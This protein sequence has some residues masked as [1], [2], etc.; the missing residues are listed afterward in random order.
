MLFRS[1][2]RAALADT[3][4][5]L[6]P[7]W[8]EW[9]IVMHLCGGHEKRLAE[10]YFYSATGATVC[11]VGEHMLH[12]HAVRIPS[13]RKRRRVAP[14]DGIWIEPGIFVKTYV[15]CMIRTVWM[16]EPPRVVREA[17][18]V[19]HEAF[20]RLVRVL[21][22]GRTAHEVDAV[23]RDFITG[24][25]FEI[26]HRTGY[27]S[28]ERWSDA[29]ILSLTPGNPLVIES[30]QVFHCPM[31]VFLPGIGYVGSSEQVHVTATGCEVVGDVSVCPRRLYIKNA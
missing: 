3:I 14:G 2:N 11:Q 20:D 7:G 4:A 29:G 12:M 10:E 8:S 17:L 6:E 9:D 15:G 19:V 22:P 5:A 1:V 23:A 27:T 26:Q 24:K 21:A 13:E 25:G 28:N 30:G 16:G 18:D 31:H